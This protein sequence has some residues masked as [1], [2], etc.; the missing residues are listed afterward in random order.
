MDGQGILY[1]SDGTVEYEGIF[2]NGQFHEFGCHNNQNP[3]IM[4]VFLDISQFP[5]IAN[6]WV[7]YEGEFF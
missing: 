1:Y 3:D 7:K 4:D 6:Y 2:Q 5:G